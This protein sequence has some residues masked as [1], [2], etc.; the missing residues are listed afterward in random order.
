MKTQLL[1]VP[2]LVL[3]LAPVAARADDQP[4]AKVL[5][6]KAIKA[7][8]GEAKLANLGNASGKGRI[9][10]SEGGQD[11][12]VDID[13]TWQG[14]NKYHAEAEFQGGGQNFKGI[15]VAN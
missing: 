12:T 3:L 11:F 15:L 14:G 10:G 5:L 8:N 1:T 7:M 13:G 6:D 9:T 2:T 4:D